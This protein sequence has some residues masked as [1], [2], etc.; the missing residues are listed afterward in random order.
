MLAKLV[1][2]ATKRYN[3]VLY[4]QVAIAMVTGTDSKS[5]EEDQ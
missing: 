1:S 5:G 3:K 2:I 4:H